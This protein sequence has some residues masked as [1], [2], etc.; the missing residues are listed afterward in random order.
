MSRL[1]GYIIIVFAL[2]IN[3]LGFLGVAKIILPTNA[4]IVSGFLSFIGSIL[5][6]IITFIGVKITLEH[7]SN[8][9]I[10]ETLSKKI[11]IIEDLIREL[12]SP[13]NV[14]F[15]LDHSDHLNETEKI[16]SYKKMLTRYEDLL[17][18]SY[19]KLKIELDYDFIKIFDFYVK[20]FGNQVFYLNNSNDPKVSIIQEAVETA[21]EIY[22]QLLLHN[23]K[24]TN[25]FY[26]IKKD[27]KKF[28]DKM[29]NKRQIFGRITAEHFD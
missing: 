18:N 6:G 13:F 23:E 1:T 3:L 19:S 24:Q 29:S 8:E 10:L 5:G 26:K 17:L 21:R 7:T 2:G 27:R 4:D 28:S 25:L 14:L 12:K 15:M 11:F 9:K 22:S 16:E 20:K